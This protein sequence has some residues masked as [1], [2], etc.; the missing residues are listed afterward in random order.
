M[1]DGTVPAPEAAG[2]STEVDP[3]NIRKYKIG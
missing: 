2:M 3:Q 1:K